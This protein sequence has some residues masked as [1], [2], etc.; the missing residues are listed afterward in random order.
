[1]WPVI[2]GR[3]N[4]IELLPVVS[5]CGLFAFW[6]EL[7]GNEILNRLII[8]LENYLW[9]KVVGR[10][11]GRGLAMG[12]AIRFSHCRCLGRNAH[13]PSQTVRSMA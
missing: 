8:G 1:M 6:D 11:M 13:Q 2:V 9:G 7:E 5:C 10:M 4:R 3:N 12:D